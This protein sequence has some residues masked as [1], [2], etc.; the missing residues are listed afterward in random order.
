LV[1]STTGDLGRNI[2]AMQAW[3]KVRGVINGRFK[4]L[5]IL[6]PRQATKLKEADAQQ[7]MRAAG[8]AYPDYSWKLVETTTPN[9]YI[10][11]GRISRVKVARST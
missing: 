6:D 3:I 11:R 8:D 7:V 1:G 9:K 5:L 10:V 4:P 2:T